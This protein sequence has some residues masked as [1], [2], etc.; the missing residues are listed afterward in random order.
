MANQFR[1]RAPSLGFPRTWSL[2]T[3]GHKDVK[4]AMRYQHPE[5]EIVPTAL[6][7]GT[8]VAGDEQVEKN[9]WHVLGHR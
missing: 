3:M 6:N 7:Q 9:L 4:T 8:G 1:L 5:I 2:K